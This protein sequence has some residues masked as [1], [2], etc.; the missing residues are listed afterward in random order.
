ML[1]PIALGADVVM[2]LEQRC[3]GAEDLVDLRFVQT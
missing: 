1:F 3:I 2:L